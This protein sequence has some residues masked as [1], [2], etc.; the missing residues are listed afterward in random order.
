MTVPNLPGTT[1]Q[2]PGDGVNNL[3]PFGFSV[4][5]TDEV[6]VLLTTAAGGTQTLDPSVY[7]IALFNGGADGGQVTYPLT[8]SRVATGDYITIQLDVDFDQ[9]TRLLDQG[10]YNAGTIERTAD[11]I[12]RQTQQLSAQLVRVPLGPPGVPLRFALPQDNQPVYWSLDADGGFTLKNGVAVQKT[13]ANIRVFYADDLGL[14]G[15]GT[16][17]TATLQNQLNSLSATGNG[18][19]VYLKSAAGYWPLTSYLAIPSGIQLSMGSPFRANKSG[20]VGFA[21]DYAYFGDGATVTTTTSAAATTL[22]VTVSGGVV[23]AVFA[24][25]DQIKVGSQIVRITGTNDGAGT[26]TLATGLTAAAS[27]GAA[28]KKLTVAY[29]TASWN[30]HDTP[31]EIAVDRPDLFSVG[32]LVLV[33]DDELTTNA[34]GVTTSLINQEMAKVIGFGSGSVKFDRSIRTWMSTSNRARLIKIAPCEYASI[35]GASVEF[36]EAPSS[37][38]V[39]VFA[40]TFAY[41]CQLLDCQVPNRDAFGTRG[42]SIF[43]D[44]CYQ[45]VDLNSSAGSAKYTG[46]GEGHGVSFNFSTD[47]HSVEPQITGARKGVS[48]I[49]CV[50]CTIDNPDINDPVI[51][52]VGTEGLKEIGCRV[53]RIEAAGTSRTSAGGIMV[54]SAAWRAGSY[55]CHFDALDVAEFQG[56]GGYA[57]QLWAQSDDCLI[58][59]NFRRCADG[60][61]ATD[62]SGAGTLL[63]GTIRINARF[64]RMDRCGNVAMATN[65]SSSKPFTR[66][67]LTGSEFVDFADGLI[68]DNVADVLANVRFITSRPTTNGYALTI[69][70][71]TVF[72]VRETVFDGCQKHIKLTGSPGTIENA[73]VR[74]PGTTTWIDELSGSPVSGGVRDIALVHPSGWTPARTSAQTT[75]QVFPLP[76]ML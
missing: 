18:C 35:S 19:I 26:V 5:S 67:D 69:T 66:L 76:G 37:T 17:E 20:S 14:K 54:G 39:D 73:R 52:A 58:T 50:D 59:G 13:P 40:S 74:N 12:V 51:C 43:W 49:G 4:S 48:L 15:D 60:I 53:V 10:A 11:H 23:S 9:P 6:A 64:V 22:P 29:A 21:G 28:V 70:N 2:L 57:V 47:C 41:K 30:R 75:L 61:L 44:R 55:E 24:A 72:R 45:C 8:T 25:N 65:G 46:T 68:V 7:S 56:S 16:D 1:G 34:D 32:D 27:A 63:I 62:Q 71:S 36:T 31:N 42:R 38:R 3:W 33:M